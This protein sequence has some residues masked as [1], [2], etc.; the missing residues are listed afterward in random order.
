MHTWSGT[1]NQA[2]AWVQKY[3]DS[4]PEAQREGPL[5]GRAT[6]RILDLGQPIHQ[7]QISTE[8]FWLFLSE[9]CQRC[10]YEPFLHLVKWAWFSQHVTPH[11]RHLPKNE[12][13]GLV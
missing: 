6:M 5:G 2:E 12:L 9:I 1:F 8:N 13:S 11:I 10:K 4:S 7:W 3:L